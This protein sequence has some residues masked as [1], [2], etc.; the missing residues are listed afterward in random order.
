M[1]ERTTDIQR[2]IAL[3]RDRMSETIAELDARISERVAVVKDHV[4]LK[5]LVKDHPW[6]ALALALGVGVVLAGTRADARAVR[7]TVRA[8]RAAPA[9]TADLA[10]RGWDAAAGVVRRDG[11]G[12]RK[13]DVEPGLAVRVRSA[14]TRATGVDELI[15]QMRDA[16]ADLGRPASYSGQNV[17]RN[18]GQQM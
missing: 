4:D 15:G 10:R 18:T 3:T 13:A 11:S 2:D 17:P 16:A 5:Q 6:P 14:I 7:A 8:A 12:D 9:A 1:S